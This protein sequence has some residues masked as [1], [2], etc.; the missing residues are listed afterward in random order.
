MADPKSPLDGAQELSNTRFDMLRWCISSRKRRILT[1]ICVVFL[2][3]LLVSPN[4]RRWNANNISQFFGWFD[5][6]FA[7]TS[8]DTG[9]RSTSSTSSTSSTT[10]TAIVKVENANVRSGAGY[11]AKVIVTLHKGNPVTL[12]GQAKTVDE[13]TWKQVRLENGKTG[14][15]IESLL[16]LQSSSP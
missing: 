14:W 6:L 5:G 16:D 15:M 13:H 11:S 3:L 12:T 1:L 8:T 9:T 10:G 7:T 2:V 4:F